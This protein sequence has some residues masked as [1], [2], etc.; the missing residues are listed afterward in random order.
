[1]CGDS[2]T[3]A[4]DSCAAWLCFWWR[5]ATRWSAAVPFPRTASFVGWR[6]R[7]LA[8]LLHRMLLAA[9]L[10]LC[11]TPTS[12]APYLT[13]MRFASRCDSV[14]GRHGRFAAVGVTLCLV[15]FRFH[16]QSRSHGR[17]RLRRAWRPAP[18][19]TGSPAKVA[20]A[21]ANCW[22]R[23]SAASTT[24]CAR[25]STR[26]SA[27]R[28]CC[29]RAWSTAR[30]ASTSPTCWRATRASRSCCSTSSSTTAARC[31]AS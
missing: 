21:R 23:S 5:C 30:A 20:R 2:S 22:S 18:A 7:V 19:P 29:S 12:Q 31:S 10:A 4:A 14:S 8:I 15:S 26:W 13:G 28:I 11:P 16:P 1:M 17:S 27:G 25:R 3:L 9:R 24:T 6:L